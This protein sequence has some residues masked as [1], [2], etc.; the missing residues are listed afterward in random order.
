MISRKSLPGGVNHTPT[1]AATDNTQSRELC[2]LGFLLALVFAG[3]FLVFPCGRR[4][5]NV[6]QSWGRL[7]NAELFQPI[8]TFTKGLDETALLTN[9]SEPNMNGSGFK[10]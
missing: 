2:G 7:R 5:R 10:P 8:N 4:L 1:F 6:E 9:G 3:P